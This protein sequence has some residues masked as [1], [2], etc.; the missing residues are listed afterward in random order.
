MQAKVPL[1]Q[2]APQTEMGQEPDA[3]T[4]KGQ[5]KFFCRMKG[6]MAVSTIEAASLSFLL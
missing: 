4:A 6:E 5:N 1:Q 2:D 3:K